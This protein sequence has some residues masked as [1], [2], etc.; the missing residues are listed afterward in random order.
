[1]SNG[2]FPGTFDRL[3]IVPT[4]IRLVAQVSEELGVVYYY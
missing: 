1:M 2:T 3:L 4:G